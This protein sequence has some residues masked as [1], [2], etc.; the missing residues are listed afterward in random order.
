LRLSRKDWLDLV[1]TDFFTFSITF[2]NK[3]DDV[4][5]ALFELTLYVPVACE[6]FLIGVLGDP[7][8]SA[9]SVTITST[10]T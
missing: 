9:T 10:L 6:L 7:S 4:N 1:T 3:S 2:I 8:L 5:F